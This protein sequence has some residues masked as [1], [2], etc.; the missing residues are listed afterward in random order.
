MPGADR[1]F[2]ARSSAV[3]VTAGSGFS[4]DEVPVPGHRLLPDK[5][6]VG[7]WSGL[8]DHQLTASLAFQ[9]LYLQRARAEGRAAR[10]S[11]ARVEGVPEHTW[12]A[13]TAVWLGGW[14]LSGCVPEARRW[15]ALLCQV[16]Q[17]I[18]SVNLSVL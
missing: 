15:P 7:L 12:A 14:A 13:A 5:V 9:Q 6:G 16:R 18:S 3:S 4:L 1:P 2:L 10:R 17:F 8:G 11:G